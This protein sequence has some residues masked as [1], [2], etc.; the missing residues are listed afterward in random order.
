MAP[1]TRT[2]ET[3]MIVRLLG[4]ASWTAYMAIILALRGSVNM[5][6]DTMSGSK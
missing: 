4:G 6:M 3:P 2:T 1:P 5:T